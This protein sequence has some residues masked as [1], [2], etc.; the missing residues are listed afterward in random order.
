M[1]KVIY[2]K[3]VKTN[4]GKKIVIKKK[5]KIRFHQNLSDVTVTEEE[6]LDEYE[7]T[8]K[9]QKKQNANLIEHN[10]VQNNTNNIMNHNNKASIKWN[11]NI[12]DISEL[13][14][15]TNSEVFKGFR[16]VQEK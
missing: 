3:E 12:K 5:R 4:E 10:K 6:K 2:T 11:N 1:D 13:D 14:T 8:K 7:K 16:K 9:K 15:P